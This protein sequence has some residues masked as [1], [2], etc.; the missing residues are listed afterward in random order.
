[1]I[2]LGISDHY[3]SGAAIIIDGRIVSAVAEERL[4]RKKMVMG[5][6]WKSIKSA[7][8]TA[9]VQPKDLTEVAIASDWGHFLKDYVDFS[10]GVFGVKE[11]F[12]RSLFFRVGSHISF[13]RSKIPLLEKLYYDLR[14]PAFEKRKQAIRQ[15]IHLDFGITAPVTFVSH[16]LCHAAGAY[17]ASGYDDALVAT[18]DGAG[19][20]DSSHVYS[21]KNGRFERLHHVPSFDSLGDYYGYVTQIS[22]FKAGKHEGKVTGLAAYGKATLKG[23]FEKF[24]CYKDGSM[25]NVGNCFRH[26]ALRKLKK[27]LP[28]GYKREDLAATIQELSEE[29]ATAYIG[30]WCKKTGHRNVA[31][32]GGVFANV[33]INQRVLETEGVSS[34][35]VFPAMSDEG[36]AAGAALV[37]H[38]EM[39]GWE[40]QDRACID[41]VYLGPEFSDEAIEKALDAA[42]VEFAKADD[43]AREV[44]KLLADGKVVARFA[45]RMEYGPRA[46]GN[47]SILYRPDNPAVNDWLNERLKRT[48][49]MPFAPATLAEDAAGYFIGIEGAENTA[50]FMTITFDCTDIMKKTCPGVVHIDG[51]ARP[52][53]VHAHD[54]PD[55]HRIISEFKRLTGLSCVVNT[56]FNIHEEPIVCTPE[57][58]I[59]AFE[60][61]HLDV[62]AIGPFIAINPAVKA[63]DAEKEER[64][65]A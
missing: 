36:I 21:V 15:A 5:F 26:A 45:G 31:L 34:V 13:L 14:K 22:G 1:M 7:M 65:I 33:K 17:Y 51:T 43:M 56:S 48:E 53:V 55:F 39:N 20:G 9:G 41:H 2:I 40:P 12:V 6:P 61:G 58:A 16:H 50:R 23:V 32:A 59:R 62:L 19:D 46:L 47:R 52:Q 63:K 54:N 60:I 38:A 18:L 25:R 4:A 8:Q 35:F 27:A 28:E 11:T 3:I 24:F 37:R 29:V 42:G 10:D 30:H 57:D 44:A 64:A 49:F